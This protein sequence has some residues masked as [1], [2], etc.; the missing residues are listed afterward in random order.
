MRKWVAGMLMV[1][2]L[3]AGTAVA[4]PQTIDLETMTTQELTELRAQ[5]DAALTSATAADRRRLHSP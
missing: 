3:L 4:A 5:V 1:A 2:M